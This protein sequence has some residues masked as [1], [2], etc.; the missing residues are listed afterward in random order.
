MEFIVTTKAQRPAE[1][2]GKCF[3]CQQPIGD[4][5]KSTCVLISKKVKVR[6]IVEYDIE[7]PA[8]W[9][10]NK[11]ESHRND[12]TWCSN[13]ALDE[14]KNLS[15]EQGCLCNVMEFECLSDEGEPFL[16]EE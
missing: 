4:V 7:V 12:G 13:N 15:D 5:H 6:M 11:I 3:Y 16:D 10:K 8:H 14:L 9:D 1:M 2:N